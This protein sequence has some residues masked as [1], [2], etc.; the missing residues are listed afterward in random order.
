MWLA[1]VVIALAA[2]TEEEKFTK[3]IQHQHITM[4]LTGSIIPFDADKATRAEDW[5]WKEGDKVYLSI[6]NNGPYDTHVTATYHDSGWEAF[7]LGENHILTRSGTCEAWYIDA[8]ESN[9][10]AQDGFSIFEGIG[11]K[12]EVYLSSYGSYE[13][14][15]D[16]EVLTVSVTLH[17]QTSRLHLVK[18]DNDN[19]NVDI[20]IKGLCYID[21]F[22]RNQ[23]SNEFYYEQLFPHYFYCHRDSIIT[24]KGSL[25]DYIYG[26]FAQGKHQLTIINNADGD[27][28]TFTRTFGDNV[29]TTGES[30]RLTIPTKDNHESLGW[31]MEER[32]LVITVPGTSV[33]FNMIHVAAGTF[34]MGAK[35]TQD[36]GEEHADETPRHAVTLTKDY[37]IGQTEVTQ[38]LWETVMGSNPSYFQGTQYAQHPV[39]Q[40]TWDECQMFIMKLNA[41]HLSSLYFRL[42]SEAEWEFAAHGGNKCKDYEKCYWYA[43]SNTVGEVAWY[44]GNAQNSTQPVASNTLK[45]N[46]LGIYD[47]SG[48]VWELCEDWYADDYY[49]SNHN[50]DPVGPERPESNPQ[51][52]QRGGSWNNE[53][54][55]SRVTNRGTW[56][57]RKNFT[58][59]RIVLSERASYHTLT[60]RNTL[61]E[62]KKE[63]GAQSIAVASNEEW[64]ATSSDPKWCS[65]SPGTG[66]NSGTVTITTTE[67][68]STSPREATITIKGQTSG[69]ETTISVTQTGQTEDAADLTLTVTGNGKTVDFKMILV[70]HGIFQMGSEESDAYSSETPVHMVTLTNDYYIGETEVTQALWYAVMGQKPTSDGAQWGSTSGLGDNRPAYYVSWNDCQEFITKLNQMTG[71]NFRLP[72]DAEWEFAAR[73]G[74]KSQGYKFAG[75]DIIDKVA[76]HYDNGDL[77]THDVGTR[78]ANELG[79]YDM[80][81]NVWEWCSDWYGRY[82]STAQ[83]NPTGPTTGSDRVTRGGSWGTGDRVCRVSNREYEGV[84]SR[85]GGGGFRLVLQ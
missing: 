6:S 36:G 78:Q 12:D 29:L 60:D 77:T 68:T 18:E 69:D 52:V 83:T 15:F 4:K 7:I 1:I 51:R 16:N 32:P 59:L 39:E 17:P 21:K 5:Q 85:Y 42:P 75:G 30:G 14:D 38:E 25:P 28:L 70:E 56:Y 74:N 23:P 40:V 46:D 58:G 82:S 79:I 9:Y 49:A 34:Q 24:I 41:L 20:T 62:F 72:T 53:A 47:M 33:K 50:T 19:S 44:S 31:T 67:N 63:G 84:D 45:P 66:A 76:W 57:E 26:N 48:N 71:K 73:G 55:S 3:D 54:K 11:Y 43:G 64:T 2:C 8:K 65:V 35:G 13:Y 81:G 37:Y 22:R 27:N 10:Q 61:E 80:S